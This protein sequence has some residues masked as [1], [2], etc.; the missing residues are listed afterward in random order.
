MSSQARVDIHSFHSLAWN[1]YKH[2]DGDFTDKVIVDIV[3]QNRSCTKLLEAY[4]I[5]VIDEAQ[6]RN[7]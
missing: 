4:E 1:H 2:G 6:V 5:I 3:N 7:C